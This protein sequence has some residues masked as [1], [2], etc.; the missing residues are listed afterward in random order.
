[1]NQN[2][3]ALENSWFRDIE[4]RLG[5]QFETTLQC[6]LRGRTEP[7]DRIVGSVPALGVGNGQLCL[8]ETAGASQDQLS[9]PRRLAIWLQNVFDSVKFSLAPDE[10]PGIVAWYVTEAQSDR[11][12]KAEAK[13]LLKRVM[14]VH[15]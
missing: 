7:E 1:M 4:D 12:I 15:Y 11:F 9:L 14:V 2:L 3:L 10:K 6:Y 5:D 8:P 13:L